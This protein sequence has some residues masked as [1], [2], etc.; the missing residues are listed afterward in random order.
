MAG[1]DQAL[2][3]Y[4]TAIGLAPDFAAAYNKESSFRVDR[5]TAKPSKGRNQP[6]LAIA[7]LKC[8]TG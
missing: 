8:I 5:T 4:T 7:F 3:D 1:L 2:D 6:S